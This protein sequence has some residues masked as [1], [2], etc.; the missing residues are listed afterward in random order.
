MAY[1]NLR[2]VLAFLLRPGPAILLGIEIPIRPV[3]L[4]AGL[5]T[6]ACLLPASDILQHVR[7]SASGGLDLQDLGTG[8]GTAPGRRDV[9]QGP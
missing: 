8:P 4:P 9:H 5:G 2:L 6:V 3:Q 1:K 7:T